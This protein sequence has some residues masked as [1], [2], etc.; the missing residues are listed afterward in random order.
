VKDPFTF[1]KNTYRVLLTRGREGLVIF[2]PPDDVM[3]EATAQ[4]L[5]RCGAVP[6]EARFKH[7][8]SHVRRK[9]E[10][11]LLPYEEVAT[12]AFKTALPL[13]AQLAAGPVGDGFFV[14]IS[15]QFREVQWMRVDPSMCGPNRFIVRATGDS[16]EPG[17]QEGDHLVFEYHRTP[18]V[19]G[20]VVIINIS[21]MPDVEAKSAIKR[22]WQKGQ[23]WLITSDNPV[24]EPMALA[25]EQV[26][27]PILGVLIGKREELRSV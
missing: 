14:S 13:V 12:E 11:L 26:R 20:Q 9:P 8:E 27:Y 19:N 18:R 4:K 21:E 10:P 5:I 15:E 3:M 7:V 25:I 22:I 2:I 6:V 16:M 1:R 17:I 23:N 24:Y